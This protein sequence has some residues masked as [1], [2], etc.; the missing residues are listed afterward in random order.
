MLHR[1]NSQDGVCLRAIREW[2]LQIYSEGE[3]FQETWYVGAIHELP[4]NRI[5]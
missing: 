4:I 3:R 2:P 1:I 5:I